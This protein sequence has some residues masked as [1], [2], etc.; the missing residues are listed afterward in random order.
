MTE[1]RIVLYQTFNK[2]R[3]LSINAIC[4]VCSYAAAATSATAAT[5]AT[6]ATASGLWY[7]ASAIRY[8]IK[9][10]I[11]AETNYVGI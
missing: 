1:S 10:R 8:A 6:T 3:Q 2:N 7:S 11:D 5:T 4:G 9:S